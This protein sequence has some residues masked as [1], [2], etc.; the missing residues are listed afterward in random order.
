MENRSDL[1]KDGLVD[2][3]INENEQYVLLLSHNYNLPLI[4]DKLAINLQMMS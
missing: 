1:V 2:P 3:F 4:S